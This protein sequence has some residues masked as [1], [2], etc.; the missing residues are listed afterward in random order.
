MKFTINSKDLLKSINIVGGLIKG[1]HT[2]PILDNLLLD[3]TGG[4]MTIVADNL[5]IRAKVVVD[6]EA[7]ESLRAC[8]P[9]KLFTS[10]LKGFP[11]GPVEIVFNQ[12]SVTLSSST[13]TYNVP[14]VNAA[15]FPTERKKDEVVAIKLNA[16]EFAEALRK[17]LMFTDTRLDT[18]FNNVLVDI[19]RDAVRIAATE[20]QAV[21]FEHTIEGSGEPRELVIS[22]T[23]ADFIAKS[24]AVNE[25]VELA[26][27]ANNISMSLENVEINAILADVRFPAYKVLFD[28]ITPDKKLVIHNDLISAAIRRLCNITD[29]SH[30]TVVFDLEPN[31]LQ[32]KFENLA[33]MYDAK[34]TLDCEFEGDPLKIGFRATFIQSILSTMEEH[35]T[36]ELSESNRPCLFTA[37]NIRAILGPVY[38]NAN[39]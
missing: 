27:S 38:T 19:S 33:Q 24:I 4:K 16:L 35:V 9:F 25:Y 28:K 8:V 36:M 21:F 12:K 37:E 5:E 11:S 22:R 10:I 32:L 20:G 30:H 3:I 7:S 17:A 39:A 14:I 23:V 18:Q 26:Y 2:M 31:H 15:D 13:G 6:V 34:E 29:E 1:N